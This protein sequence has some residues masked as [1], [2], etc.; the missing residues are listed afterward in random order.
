MSELHQS[1]KAIVRRMLAGDEMAFEEF[2]ETY[3]PGLYRFALTRLDR[4]ADAAEEVVQ[5]TL[6]RAV[7]KL[8]TYRGEAALFT[9]LCTF[10]RHEISAHYD[11]HR[12]NQHETLLVEDTPEI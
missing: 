6:C 4:N 8:A 7:T 10:C 2:F 12:R 3:F 11:R 1:D 9:W 5:A